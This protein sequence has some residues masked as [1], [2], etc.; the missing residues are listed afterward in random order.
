MKKFDILQIIFGVLLSV[1]ALYF[2][3]RPSA[4]NSAP[5]STIPLVKIGNLSWDQ[6]EMTIADVKTFADA[7][8][9]VSQAEKN[10]GGLSYEAGFV[11]KPGW[12]WKTPYGA[13]AK[14]SEPAVHLNQA[15]VQSVCRFYGKRL[16][17]NDEWVSAAF[18]EQRANPPEGFTRG[19]RHPFP[20]GNTPTVSHCLSGCGDYQGVAP[21]GALNRG[22]GHVPAGITKP[23]VNG[24]LDMG[25]NVWEWTA[26]ERNGGYITRGASWWYGPERQ[27]ESDVESKP[28]DIAVVYIGFRCVV[29]GEK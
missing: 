28:G 27:K 19:Q 13:P 6:T 7:T 3:L 23:G 20:G 2:M 4:A 18:V 10:G 12:T 5:A 1:I 16:P 9:F 26:T 21:A 22:T 14:S 29:G 11:K 24:L 15:E 25:G 17:T 8:G